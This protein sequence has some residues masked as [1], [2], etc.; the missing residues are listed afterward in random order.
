[1]NSDA[2]AAIAHASANAGADDV[3]SAYIEAMSRPQVVAAYSSWLTTTPVEN[4]CLDRALHE[5][6]DVLDLGCGAGRLAVALRGRCGSYLGVD[7]SEAMICAAQSTCPDL[8]FRVGDIVG[9]NAPPASLDLVLV[10]HNVLDC[11]HP[12]SRR[13]ALLANCER[14]LRT[15]GRLIVSS[16][17]IAQ[18]QTRGYHVEDYHGAS[19]QNY[20]SSLSD[21][22]REVEDAGMEVEFAVR[23]YRGDSADWAYVVARTSKH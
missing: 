5:K 11:L 14:W 10:M 18:G 2:A 21:V 9:L 8:T 3:E 16:H 1:M 4:M 6:A 23:D 13:H 20:R 19:V 7:A 22:V 17:L 12:A 15:G